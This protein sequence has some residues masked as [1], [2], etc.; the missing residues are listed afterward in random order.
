MTSGII[1][2]HMM[3]HKMEQVLHGSFHS[4]LSDDEFQ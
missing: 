1:K 2:E 3:H 4:R